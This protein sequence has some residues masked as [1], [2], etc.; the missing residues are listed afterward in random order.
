M[1]KIHNNPKLKEPRM[2]FILPDS[3]ADNWLNPI[4]DDLDKKQIQE[5]IQ[6]FPEDKMSCYTVGKL[7]GK[8][9]VGNVPTISEKHTY[10]D[11]SIN[12]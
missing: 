8:D 11:L 1:S 3:L 10:E 2:P 6:S 12:F 5:M 7:R 9:Y 4:N